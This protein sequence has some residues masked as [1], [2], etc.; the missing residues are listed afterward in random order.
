MKKEMLIVMTMIMLSLSAC[1]KK[2][3]TEKEEKQRL[4]Y[5]NEKAAMDEMKEKVPNT[6]IVAHV[7][8]TNGY[9]HKYVDEK[10]GA[11]CYLI[12]YRL[13]NLSCVK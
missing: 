10:T 8:G 4:I 3:E 12:D 5:L 13:D 6:E 1:G 9:I 2:E 7:Q 11:T